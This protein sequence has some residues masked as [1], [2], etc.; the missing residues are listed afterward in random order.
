MRIAPILILLTFFTTGLFSCGENFGES[1]KSNPSESTPSIPEIHDSL[2]QRQ[3]DMLDSLEKRKK[4]HPLDSLK[5]K[6]AT[7]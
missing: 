6:V 7:R 3:R 5:P 2:R 1:R 4:P